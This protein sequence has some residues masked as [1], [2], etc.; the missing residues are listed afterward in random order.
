MGNTIKQLNEKSA[1]ILVVGAG[2]I[3]VEW[4]TELEHFFPKLKLTILDALPQCLGPLPAK[5]AQYCS[6]YME[7]HGINQFYSTKF[8]DKNPEFWTKIKLP[9]GADKQYVCIGV[10]ASNYFMPP[11]TLS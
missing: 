8:D 9:N 5:A 7:R 3:G 1:T 4:I 10:K 6:N 11:E 2:F